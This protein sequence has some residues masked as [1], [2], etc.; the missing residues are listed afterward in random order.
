MT[1]LVHTHFTTRL[2]GV[3]QPPYDSLNLGAHVGDDPDA[4]RENRAR[5]AAQLNLDPARFIWM[6]QVHSATVRVVDAADLGAP[7]PAT[8]AVVTTDP[9]VVLTVMV[10]DCVPVLL[11]DA[12]AGVIAAA[13]AGRTGARNG[14]V[15][16]TV[17]TMVELGAKPGNIT[18]HLGPAASGR[19]YELPREM[20]EDVEEQLPGS[21]TRT[22]HGTWGSDVR[23]GLARQLTTLGVGNIIMDPRC[24]IED[25]NLFS[26][27]RD[28]KTGR[29]AGIIW[30][31]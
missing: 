26:Y 18:A 20:A 31:E 29:Q 22:D 21:L 8:D 15:S 14:V 4:V 3:S 13:H 6:D 28:G 23:A 19:R 1:M 25:S 30:G 27:R 2:G 16:N 11:Y 5:V 7:I 9:T 10:A 12:D 24:T 17:A